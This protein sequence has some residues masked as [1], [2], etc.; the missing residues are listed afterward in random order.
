MKKWFIRIV[1]LAA[2]FGG[3]A[4][5]LQKWRTSLPANSASALAARPTTAMVETRSIHFAVN[6]AG[7]IGPAEQVSVRPE[8]NGKINS[9]PVDIGDQ[10]KQDAVLFTLDDQDLQTERAQRL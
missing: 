1:V 9:L 3:G 10:I 5:G 4:W 2:V 8:I 6:A 7:D